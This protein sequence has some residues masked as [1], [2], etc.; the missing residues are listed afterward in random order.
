MKCN[1]KI[2]HLVQTLVLQIQTFNP[3]EVDLFYK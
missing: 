2:W 1:A 3:F